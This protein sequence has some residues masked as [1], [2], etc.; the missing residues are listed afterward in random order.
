[1]KPYDTLILDCPDCKEQFPVLTNH[2]PC[3]YEKFGVDNAPLTM[4]AEV[5]EMSRRGEIRCIHCG[6]TI[7]LHVVYAARC[8]A[9]SD[10][11]MEGWKS[12]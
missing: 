12:I 10:C 7:A 2:G 11:C 6:Y 1:M 9:L 8:R 5:N 4:I 3:T